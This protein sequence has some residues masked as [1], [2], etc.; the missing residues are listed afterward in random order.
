MVRPG[1]PLPQLKYA[2]KLE[3]RDETDRIYWKILNKKSHY[4]VRF[5]PN[6]FYCLSFLF[7]P[8]IILT[9]SW[10]WGREDVKW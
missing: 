3:G 1:T 5:V 2:H 9:N 7:V 6:F 8:V 10:Q 4:D